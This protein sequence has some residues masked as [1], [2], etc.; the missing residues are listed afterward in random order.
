VAMLSISRRSCS[1]V[2]GLGLQ[3]LKIKSGKHM[4]SLTCSFG[5]SQ[6]QSGDIIDRLL[7]RADVALY[8]AK[9]SGRNC[10]VSDVSML[11]ETIYDDLGSVIR[12]PDAREP[13]PPALIKS[14]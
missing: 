3:E 11:D 1:K 4:I 12:R 5:V 9:K 13:Q 8:K 10:V 7:K 14:D 6:W 2:Y